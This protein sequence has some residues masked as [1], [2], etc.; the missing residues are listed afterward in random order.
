MMFKKFSSFSAQKFFTQQGV[1]PIAIQKHFF[2]PTRLCS[3][4]QNFSWE[5]AQGRDGEAVPYLSDWVLTIALGDQWFRVA[6]PQNCIVAVNQQQHLGPHDRGAGGFGTEAEVAL[7]G[8]SSAVEDL[9]DLLIRNA[10]E[11]SD[12]PKV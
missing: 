10:I 11:H 7:H 4:V 12:A 3:A 8:Y 6:D 5:P 1:L 2:C 9:A